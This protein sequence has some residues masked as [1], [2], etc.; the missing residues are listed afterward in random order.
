MKGIVTV[1]QKELHR[2]RVLHMVIEPR[3]VNFRSGCPV[4]RDGAVARFDSYCF[5]FDKGWWGR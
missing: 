2:A 3:I 1:S 4:D 5:K